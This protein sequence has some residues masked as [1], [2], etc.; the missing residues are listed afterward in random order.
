MMF[1]TTVIE[2]TVVATAA[3]A[4]AFAETTAIAA[5]MQQL[6]PR[7]PFCEDDC[8]CC[9]N[10]TAVAAAAFA[11]TTAVAAAMQQQLPPLPLL[12]HSRRRAMQ[13]LFLP[14]LLL[15][16]LRDHSLL[17]CSEPHPPLPPR[18]NWHLQSML[19]VRSFL[20]L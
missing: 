2:T 5:A 9:C 1:Q 17:P 15:P 4:A 8:R 14:P 11:E 6:L 19:M 20:L 13:L 10:A 7:R 16:L 12:L 18:W 3:I